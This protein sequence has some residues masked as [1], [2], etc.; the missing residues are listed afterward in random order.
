MVT[1]IKR[2]TRIHRDPAITHLRVPRRRIHTHDV[3]TRINILSNRPVRTN[4]K[5]SDLLSAILIPQLNRQPR[6]LLT[7]ISIR[8]SD[9]ARVY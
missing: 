7:I 8:T 9:A 1:K 6:D 5:I 4:L 2:L 3:L